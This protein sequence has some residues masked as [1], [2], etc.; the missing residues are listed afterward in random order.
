MSIKVTGIKQAV[1]AL[2]DY[3]DTKTE[4]LIDT[5]NEAVINIDRKAKKKITADEHIDTGRLRAS[6][7]PVPVGQT[8]SSFNYSDNE[9]N[10]FDGATNVDNDSEEGSVVTNVEYGPK[11]EA[12]DSFMFWAFEQ[13]R[14]KYIKR[15]KKILS[16]IR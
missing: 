9:G 6:I 10:S 5:T 14:P 3:K 1:K 4:R 13:E 7:H 16:S 11:I 15:A 12:M 2:E 8:D